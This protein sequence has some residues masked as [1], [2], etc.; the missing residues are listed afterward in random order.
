MP[1]TASASLSDNRLHVRKTEFEFLRRKTKTYR[2]L[3][4]VRHPR[5]PFPVAVYRDADGGFTA[6]Y[7]RCTH[8]GCE[9]QALP[10]AMVCPCHGSEFAISGEVLSPPADRPLTPLRITTDHE[11]LF[12]HL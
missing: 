1:H 3:V 6:Q 7:L 8:R 2:A 4:L 12:V 11:T 9:L 5:V 10:T